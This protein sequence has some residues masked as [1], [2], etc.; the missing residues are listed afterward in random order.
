MSKHILYYTSGTT[1]YEREWYRREWVSQCPYKDFIFGGECQGIEN[2]D[3]DH[4]RYNQNGDLNT[5]IQD[6][7]K[8]GDQMQAVSSSTPPGHKNYI[9]PEIKR[10]EYYLSQY[11]ESLVTDYLVIEKLEN[12][13]YPEEEC[14]ITKP[15][16][17]QDMENLDD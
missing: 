6:K 17:K 9:T 11:E 15:C 13:E 5:H 2:H 10:E 14:A 16:D 12:D 8:T 7:D 1:P 4:W 3:G